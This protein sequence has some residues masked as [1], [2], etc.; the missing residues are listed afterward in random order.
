MA[1]LTIYELL[2]MAVMSVLLGIIFQRFIPRKEYGDPL[3]QIHPKFDWKHIQY[4]SLIIA[5]AVILH[6]FGHKFVAMSFGADATFFA[7]LSLNKL[8]NGLPFLDTPAILMIVAVVMALSGSS[9]IF[10][11]PAYVAWSGSVTHLQVALIA[12]A[13]PIV[14]G[15]LWA[16]SRWMVK[17]E[18]M[19]QYMRE[20]AIFGKI[21]G[22]LAIFQ[23]NSIPWFRWVPWNN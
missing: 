22:F 6:E 16:L 3:L 4:V 9:F 10:F 2:D 23:H 11:I 5:P 21:N 12:Y 15:V 19:K 8:I 18:I 14:N 1:L 7:S 13:G 20:I 17:K